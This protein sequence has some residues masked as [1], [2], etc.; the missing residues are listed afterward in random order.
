MT[1]VLYYQLFEWVDLFTRKKYR[2]SWKGWKPLYKMVINNNYTK[3]SWLNIRMITILY[4][5]LR[6]IQ[7]PKSIRSVC[8]YIFIPL[9]VKSVYI[10]LYYSDGPLPQYDP[11]RLTDLSRLT[12]FSPIKR[13]V[14]PSLCQLLRRVGRR[15]FHT[16]RTEWQLA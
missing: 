4:F 16:I 14:Q 9:G 1:S 11:R 6:S 8:I 7:K 5:L 10:Y 3:I 13:S 12:V 15:Q 2:R